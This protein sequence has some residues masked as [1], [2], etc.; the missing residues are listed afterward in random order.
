MLSNLEILETFLLRVWQHQDILAIPDFIA[1]D[2]VITGLEESDHIGWRQFQ[3]FHRMLTSQFD[4]IRHD[5]ELGFEHGEWVALK[6]RITATFRETGQTVETSSMMMVRIAEGVIVEAHN[7]I[8]LIRIFE[9]IGRLPE[10][11]LDLCLLGAK[12]NIQRSA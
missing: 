10:R 9:R 12:L 1:E 3:S 8:D 4:D 6:A 5:T 2:A 7:Q 11:S